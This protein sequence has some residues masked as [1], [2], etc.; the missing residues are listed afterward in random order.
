VSNIPVPHGIRLR[1]ASGGLFPTKPKEPGFRCKNKKLATFII[2]RFL[3]LFVVLFGV[4]VL[5]FSILMTFS[6]ERRA[7]AYVSSPQQ[8][9][10]IPGLV[11]QLGLNDPFY[12]QYV[13]W[14]KEI[15]SFNFGWSLVAAKPVWNAFWYYLPITLELNLFAAP[16]IIIFGIWLGTQAG[17]HRDTFIDHSTRIFAIIGWSLPTFLFAL[18][19]LMVFY[20]YFDMFPPGIISDDLSIFIRENPDE[21]TQYTHM[22]TID[23]ILNGRLD[24]TLDSLKH[25]AMPVFTQVVVV[26]ALLMR[27]MRSSMIEEIS[28]EYILTAR[29]KGADR[30]TVFF[31]HAR[32]NALIPVVTV[33]GWLVAFS[34]E[35]SISVEIIFNRQGIGWWLAQ[36]A[37][38]LDIPVL[39]GVCMFF[40]LVYVIAN[41]IIDIL[42]AYIDPRIRLG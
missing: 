3:F 34:M 38:A 9:K 39:M 24:I 21:F 35:G 13:R 37:I 30:R 10:D 31:K 42:Y 2:R 27:V 5:I 15:C 32:K 6:P 25:L 28:K 26:V 4:S 29:A 8:V 36:S 12:I 40:G 7:A 16:L 1:S 11:Q 14:A 17:I 19:M 20:G 18:I 22:Y 33:A 41:L 23:G